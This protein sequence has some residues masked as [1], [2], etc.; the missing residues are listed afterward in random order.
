MTTTPNES[1]PPLNTKKLP[2]L[3]A[4]PE[5][6]ERMIDVIENEIFPKTEKSVTE[7][8]NKV[9]GAAILSKDF[10]TTIVSD[11]NHEMDCPL[12]HGEIYVIH[13]MSKIIPAERRGDV[14]AE[15]IFVSTHVCADICGAVILFE[16]VH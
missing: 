15:S 8:G 16:I 1:A 3:K 14:A 10:D 6:L 12:Y 9:F 7:D 2:K 13:E 5:Q 4:T 11:T